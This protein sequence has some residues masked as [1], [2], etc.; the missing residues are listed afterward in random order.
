[1]LVK[2]NLTVGRHGS[3]TWKY[4]RDVLIGGHGNVIQRRGGDLPLRLHWVFHLGFALGVVVRYLWD[5]ATTFLCDIVHTYHWNALAMK[6]RWMFHLRRTCDVVGTSLGRTKRRCYDVI[7][8]SSCWV[9]SYILTL[10]LKHQLQLAT[11]NLNH[12]AEHILYQITPEK[13]KLLGSTK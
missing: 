12:L 2:W 3:I 9:G 8:T 4:H 1:M 10:N 5:V 11:K 7:T 13:M 6:R